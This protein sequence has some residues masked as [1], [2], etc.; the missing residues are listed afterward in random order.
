MVDASLMFTKTPDAIIGDS[1][2]A[3]RYTLCAILDNIELVDGFCV[4]MG[5]DRW[6]S[7]F[8]PIDAVADGAD[9]RDYIKPVEWG[10]QSVRNLNSLSEIQRYMTF[11]LKSELKYIQSSLAKEVGFGYFT[12]VIAC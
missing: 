4:D 3:R 2:K 1:L 7:C 9:L 11:A 8:I 6:S 5:L 10:L 12:I